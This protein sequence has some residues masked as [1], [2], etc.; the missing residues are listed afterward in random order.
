MF[1]RVKDVRAHHACVRQ[2]AVTN[3]S[4]PGPDTSNEPLNAEEISLGVLLRQRNQ[5]GA[6]ASAKIDLERSTAREDRF[7]IKGRNEAGHE[8]R[9][10]KRSRIRTHDRIVATGERRATEPRNP[11]N[12]RQQPLPNESC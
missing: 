8:F 9:R 10:G 6:V 12:N 2:L 4:A 5:N 11:T 7:E 3:I 1:D